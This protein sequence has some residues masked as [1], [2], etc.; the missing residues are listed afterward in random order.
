MSAG[1]KTVWGDPADVAKVVGGESFDA[2]LDNNGKDLD[3]VRC[4]CPSLISPL[5]LGGIFARE[6]DSSS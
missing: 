6:T 5:L 4:L 1:G 2:V 3:T